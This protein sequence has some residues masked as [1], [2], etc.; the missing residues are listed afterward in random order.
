MSCGDPAKLI[1]YRVVRSGSQIHSAV[2]QPKAV[3]IP[4]DDD[5]SISDRGADMIAFQRSS[6]CSREWA[7]GKFGHR[8]VSAWDGSIRSPLISVRSNKA[9]TQTPMAPPNKVASSPA[10]S[11]DSG[12]GLYRQ[13]V[14]DSD[15]SPNND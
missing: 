7:D 14:N 2:Q 10:P 3:P 9:A 11:E 15:L 12:V 1:S 4:D 5:Q 6:G 13:M 8:L